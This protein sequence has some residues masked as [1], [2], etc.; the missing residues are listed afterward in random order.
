VIWRCHLNRVTLKDIAHEVGVSV[1]T[2]SNVVNGHTAHVSPRTAARVRD[3]IAVAGYVPNAVA[4]SLVAGSARLVGLVLPA[5]SDDI[6]LLVSPHDS[7]VAGSIEAALRARDYH[8]ILRGATTSNELRDSVQRW[9][10]DGIILMGF[11]DDELR[12]LSLDG[13]VPTVVIDSGFDE[14]SPL[15]H[16]RSDD[17]NGGWLAAEH[18]TS[19]GHR[20]L[21]FCGPVSRGSQVVSDRL[22]GFRAGATARGIEDQAVS[23]VDA[24]TTYEAGCVLGTTLA[25]RAG[26]PTGLF[27]T[28]DILA[29]GLMHGLTLGGLEVP[30]A[31]SV[32]GYDDTELARF[33]APRLTTIAQ[34]TTRKGRAAAD[35]LLGAVE[36]S[37]PPRSEEIGV[38]LVVREST[39]RCRPPGS[40]LQAV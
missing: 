39:T 7:A 8:L 28:A 38:T 36:G 19:L 25:Q 1:M 12:A 3:A 30:T 31:V 37:S 40:P 20:Q 2:V 35:L 32:V 15:W 21:M 11:T 17:F 33:V 18:L 14:G 10:L 9:A 24:N 22:A 27:A 29:V 5:R 34:D 26:R 16:V 23:V 6:S 4:R 13:Q